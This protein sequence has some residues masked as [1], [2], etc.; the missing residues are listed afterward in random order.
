MNRSLQDKRY[1]SRQVKTPVEGGEFRIAG[2]NKDLDDASLEAASNVIS[3]IVIAKYDAQLKDAF[4]NTD[5]KYTKALVEG[6]NKVATEFTK[7]V[8]TDQAVKKYQK[9]KESKNQKKK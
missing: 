7:D 4:K 1:G 5:P 6:V 9:Y 2:I 8:I 3:S